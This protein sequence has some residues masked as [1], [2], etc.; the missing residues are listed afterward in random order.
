MFNRLKDL[1]TSLLVR[2]KV[3]GEEGQAMVEY[4]IILGLVSVAAIALLVT[5]GGDIAKVFETIITDL[6]GV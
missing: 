3:A 5:I 1:A 2:V 4:G 6:K